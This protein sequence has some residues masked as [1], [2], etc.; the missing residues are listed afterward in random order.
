MDPIQEQHILDVDRHRIDTFVA[1][2]KSLGVHKTF[3]IC[4]QLICCLAFYK[5]LLAICSDQSNEDVSQTPRYL[6]EPTASIVIWLTLRGVQG[7]KGCFFLDTTI[8]LHLLALYFRKLPLVHV[9]SL[10]ISSC[11]WW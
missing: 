5:H 11:R 4:C 7:T 3:Y 2:P 8:Y 1:M 10:F 6:Y 9:H